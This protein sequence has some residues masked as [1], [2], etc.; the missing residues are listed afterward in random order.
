MIVVLMRFRV[1]MLLNCVRSATVRQWWISVGLTAAL[2]LVA[3]AVYGG[4]GAVVLFR[5][6]GSSGQHLAHELMLS[7]FLFML[8]GSVP[9]LAA[10]LLHPGDADLLGV[11]PIRARH[12]IMM[13]MIE[14]T[15]AC[16]LQFAPIG[17]P[18]VVACAIGMGAPGRLWALLLPFGL[19]AVLLPSCAAALVLLA[20]VRWLGLPRVRSAAALVNLLLGAAV[21]LVVVSQVTGLRL[22]EGLA[23]LLSGTAN[24]SGRLAYWPPWSWLARA[25]LALAAGDAWQ[26]ARAL[27]PAVAAVV[28][29]GVVAVWFGEGM[30]GTGSMSEGAGPTWAARAPRRGADIARPPRGLLPAPLAGLILKEFR[31]T[32]RDPLLLAQAGMP[33]ILFLVP[34]VMALNPGFRA[35]AGLD[36]LFAFTVL[37]ILLVVYMQASILSA[38]S[39]GLDGRAFWVCL[40][41]PTRVRD[42]VCA[43][44]LTSWLMSSALGVSMVCLAGIA[45]RAD[46]MAIG[47]LVAAVSGSAAGLC[48]IGVG[49]STC[50]P[51]FTFENPAH[52]V[53]PIAIVLGFGIGVAYSGVVWGA[54]GG[55]WFGAAQWPEHGTAMYLIGG[56][57]FILATLLA[58]AVP[59]GL[60]ARRLSMLEWE[61]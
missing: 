57:V 43:K 4:A 45:L 1:R 14:G 41:S 13:R 37:M 55:A 32:V 46:A 35:Q 29:L 61:Q 9:F 49:I 48:G 59:L 24:P 5:G 54:L 44:W 19:L 50:V 16:A 23:S 10:T 36:E 31:Y 3:V 6:S 18:A 51:C 2:L 42:V 8:A 27:L 34:F 11:A 28:G 7:V 53:S 17:G 26:F 38:S 33:V 21:C 15:A 52:R 39:V 12:V 40:V 47:V 30:F 58:L 20:A 56:G 60:G 22:Q 25:L